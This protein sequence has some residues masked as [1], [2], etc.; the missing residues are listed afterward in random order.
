MVNVVSSI[1][2]IVGWGYI[3]I[4]YGKCTYIKKLNILFSSKQKKKLKHVVISK[5][6]IIYSKAETDHLMSLLGHESTTH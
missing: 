4:F 6:R 3:L 2:C 5:T 1:A